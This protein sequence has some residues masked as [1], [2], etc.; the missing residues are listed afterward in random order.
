MRALLPGW[1]PFLVPVLGVF[2]ITML[3]ALRQSLRW[4]FDHR[5]WSAG[6]PAEWRPQL[7]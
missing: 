4:R 1:Q 3:V 2:A 5:P 7:L 6:L